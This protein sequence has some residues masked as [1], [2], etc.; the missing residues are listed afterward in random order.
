MG[1]A[2]LFALLLLVCPPLQTTVSAPP[3]ARPAPGEEFHYL[4]F[5][6]SNPRPAGKVTFRVEPENEGLLT[7]EVDDRGRGQKLASRFRFDDSG[8]PVLVQISGNDY[9]KNPVDERFELAG[10]RAV[11]SNAAERGDAKVSGPAFY[12]S[13]NGSDQ[14]IGL[15][16]GALLRRP[17][18]RLSLLP[19]GEASLERVASSRVQ[20]AGKTRDLTLYG[21]SG[22][23][24]TPVYVW[25][26]G[27]GVFFGRYDGF[28]TV[29]R[30]GWEDAAG[31]LIEVQTA[32]VAA[33][34]KELAAKLAR[35]PSGPLA[36][37]GARLFD[38]ATG[39]VL[40]DSTVV[41]SGNR[42]EAVG[43][44]GEV[45]A[46]PGAQVVEAKG[47][48][49]LPG[50][51]DMHR[52]FTG[53]D[54]ILDLAAGVTTGRDLGN[55][56]DHLLD[57]K[58]RWEMGEALGPRVVPAGVIDGP[59]P[60]A[61]PTKVLVATDEE[62]R[63]AVARYAGLGYR[64]IKIY[65]SLD[66]KLVPAIMAEARQRGL[67]VSGHIPHGLNA[68]QAVRLGFEEVHHVNFLFLNFLAGVDTRTPARVSAAAEHAAELDLASEPV[69]AF[70]RLLKERNV[71]VDP[72]LSLFE[73]RLTGRAGELG[74][75]MAAIADRL[76]FQVRRRL[77]GGVL[78]VPAGM[79]QRYRDSFRAM[80]A[81][82]RAVH[83]AGIPIVAGTD[84]PPGF[85]YHRELENYVKAG[86][87]AREVLKL[88]TLGAA[89]V[90]RRDDE[91]GT[92]APGK[93]ADL[94]LVDGDPTTNISDIRR[95][96][97]TIKDGV[98]HDTAELY[99]AIGVKPVEERRAP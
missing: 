7:L 94:I 74:P 79:E 90:A 1:R 97:L 37:Q 85:L 12:Y 81:L 15:L 93:L 10:G 76:P 17:D 28:V 98:L 66:P 39:T 41:I 61:S 89:R 69:R 4:V 9:W 50:L 2:R 51:W 87:P 36:I 3:A 59:G 88:A 84:G 8:I 75:S 52:H 58:R 34:Q 22:L 11:W 56:S 64:Q 53:A 80:L 55:D 6:G 47:K 16:A 49:L 70:L 20:L 35:R 63:A 18:H 92:I 77:L 71:V 86:I 65:S 13:L 95:V 62:A 30:Q 44:S 31:E 40:P 25:M 78:P 5:L 24:Y 72:T 14:E 33:R 43:R 19:G 73:D 99:K 21:I 27:P 23:G 91:L 42:F 29:V 67:R 46:P 96:V 68:E 54:G 45:P 32:A 26:E 38:P 57:L 60:Y 83:E 48:M 82:V